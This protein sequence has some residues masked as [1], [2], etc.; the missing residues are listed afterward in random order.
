MNNTW[1]YLAACLAVMFITAFFPI[2]VFAAELPF[3][4]QAKSAL[5]LDYDTG[6]ILY[7]KNPH[8]KLPMASITK[9]MT[10]LLVLEAIDDGRINL[11]TPVQISEYAAGMGGSQVLLYPGEILPVS[12]LLKA[13]IVASGND[14]SVALAEKVYGTHEYF[15]QKMNERAQELGMTNTHF[16]NCTGLPADKHY[17]TAYDI[18]LMSREL[19]KYPL[20]FKW[21]SIWHDFL[22]ECRNKT[23]L[24][25]TNRLVRFYDGCDGIKTGSTSE[26]K[27]CLSATAKRGN[28]RVISIIMAAPTSEVRFAEARKLMDFGFANYE[29]IPVVKK[30]QIVEK[31]LKISGGK[32]N[33]LNGIAAQDFSFLI[34]KGEPKETTRKTELKASLKA[35]I[36]KGEKIGTLILEK[37]DEI[38]ATVDILADR[39]IE[40]A[41]LFD[42]LYKIFTSWM[43]KR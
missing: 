3:E 37:D 25:N 19:L 21:S 33:I 15:V 10:I 31:D 39:T 2:N 4:V 38:I 6:T 40:K 20:F 30:D 16:A 28:M 29:V 32:T 43:K 11:D 35:P 41:N 36:K 42:Y 9:I 34:K 24:T 22:E 23:D 12:A 5:L 13:T 8:E 7:E 18:S 26:A 1:R 17:T 27:F 14:S